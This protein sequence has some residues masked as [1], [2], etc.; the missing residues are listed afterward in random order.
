MKED[1]TKSAV[2]GSP[3]N[4]LIFSNTYQFFYTAFLQIHVQN[5]VWAHF[6]HNILPRRHTEESHTTKLLV[7]K[8]I[9]DEMLLN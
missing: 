7:D 6:I 1:K 4:N 3:N 9:W 2:D 8:N 5:I